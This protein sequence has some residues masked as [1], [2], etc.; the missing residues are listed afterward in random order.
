MLIRPKSHL[1]ADWAIEA[2]EA[3][4]AVLYEKPAGRGSG[5]TARIVEAVERTGGLFRSATAGA[6]LRRSTRCR[7]C[8]KPGV[9][10]RS[11]RC[12]HGLLPRRGR[13][14]H[15][16]IRVTLVARCSSSA[17]TRSTVFCCT[18]VCQVGQR[19][20]HQVP[21][22]FGETSREDAAGA[23]LNYDD[24]IVTLDFMA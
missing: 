12:A 13:Y 23:I 21:G 20:H 11:S 15:M 3:G 7:R 4:K 16:R 22:V 9:W 24:K 1:M 17:A 8:W 6:T 10:A 5:D 19:P 18:S 14:G 2:L